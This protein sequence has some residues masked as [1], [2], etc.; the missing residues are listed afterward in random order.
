MRRSVGEIPSSVIARVHTRA[1]RRPPRRHEF[2]HLVAGCLGN[3]FVLFIVLDCLR[4]SARGY[5]RRSVEEADVE[6][7]MLRLCLL[8]E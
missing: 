1:T 2:G 3:C 7:S 6:C 4:Y 8:R 5:R